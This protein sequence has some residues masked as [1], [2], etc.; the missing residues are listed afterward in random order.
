MMAG[1]CDW[2]PDYISLS[3]GDQ[4]FFATTRSAEAT[5]LV[6]LRLQHMAE[7]LLRPDDPLV[8]YLH[9]YPVPNMF[10]TGSEHI[11]G[12]SRTCSGVF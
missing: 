9:L 5:L 11:R 7:G 10:W 12:K 1:R 3:C 4:V 2:P 8:L 6:A